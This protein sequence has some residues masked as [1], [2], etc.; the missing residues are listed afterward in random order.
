MK[1]IKSLVK[2]FWRKRGFRFTKAVSKER[3][4]LNLNIGCGS[5]ELNGFV[6]LDF[7]SQHYYPSGTFNRAFYDIRGDLLPYDDSAIYTIYCSHVIEHIKE[8][9]IKTFFK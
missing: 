9:F 5:Y 7:F 3:P 8:K 6:S 1:T 4:G 2:S